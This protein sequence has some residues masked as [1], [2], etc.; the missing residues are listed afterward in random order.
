MTVTALTPY[1]LGGSEIP[2]VLGLDP[3]VSAYALACRK[4]GVSGESTTSPAALMG[5]RLQAVH[6][7]L[8]ADDG[9]TVMPAPADGI[10]HPDLPWLVGHPDAFVVL[11]APVVQRGAEHQAPK[12]P[13]KGT[14]TDAASTERAPLELKLRGL[15]PSEPMRMRDTVQAL[16]YAELCDSSQAMVSELHGGF[17]GIVRDE[18]T[19]ER[20][21]EL[22]ALIVRRCEEFLSLIRRGKCPD[23]DGSESALAAQR[24]RW[25]GHPGEQMRLSAGGWEHLQASRECREMIAALKGQQAYHDQQV[26]DEMGDATEVVSPLD[27]LACR[28]QP[29]T[30]RRL[31]QGALKLAHPELYGEYVRESTTRRFE[32]NP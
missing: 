7:E 30:T 32:A 8:V 14:V 16:V 13:V 4:L 31:D 6:A 10:A 23:P 12:A 9:Y 3:Y 17:G 15:A 11:T 28:W 21:P 25:A 1:T 27:T 18:W 2:A 29:V 19:V 22:F 5:N 24:S 20:D 26:M